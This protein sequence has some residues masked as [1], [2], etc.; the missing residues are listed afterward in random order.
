MLHLYMIQCIIV[1]II[2]AVR[3]SIIIYHVFVPIPFNH[4]CIYHYCLLRKAC[5]QAKMSGE[6]YGILANINTHKDQLDKLKFLARVVVPSSPQLEGC[7]GI[8]ELFKLMRESQALQCLDYRYAVSLLRHML[9]VVRCN[10]DKKLQLHCHIEFDVEK[11]DSMPFYE[12]LVQL[13]NKLDQNSSNYE[14]LLNSIDKNKLS[15]PKSDISSP[16]DLLQSMICR[17]ILDPSNPQS[18]EALVIIL[19]DAELEDEAELIQQS[20]HPGTYLS[21][22]LAHVAT[23]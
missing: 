9:V 6:L 21:F 1:H 10:Q 4:V 15:K 3:C 2:R 18:L 12:S 5:S 11:F 13:A 8:P 17:G 22:S 23:L 14:R 16:L 20:L 7:N 19:G